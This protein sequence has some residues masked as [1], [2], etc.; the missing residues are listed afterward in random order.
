MHADFQFFSVKPLYVVTYKE[1]Q[2]Q[3]LH[4][5]QQ[6]E[7]KTWRRSGKREL[8]FGPSCRAETGIQ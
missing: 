7:W 1:H 6:A 8:D 3:P 5:E 2:V 4:T